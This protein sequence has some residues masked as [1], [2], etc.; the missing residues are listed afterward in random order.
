[1]GLKDVGRFGGG[2]CDCG[3][4]GGGGGGDCDCGDSGGGGGGDC[5]CGDSGGGDVNIWLPASHYVHNFLKVVES[6]SSPEALSVANYCLV[7]FYLSNTDDGQ[8]I[9]YKGLVFSD[10]W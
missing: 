6:D 9:T 5:D 8:E 10:V 3:D 2:D 4:S 7:H 1:M